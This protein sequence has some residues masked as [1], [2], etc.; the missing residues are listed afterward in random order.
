M[1]QLR[2]CYE[3]LRMS[4]EKLTSVGALNHPSRKLPGEEIAITFS[5]Q[6]FPLMILR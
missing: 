6:F 4:L 2:F 5:C 1:S 3:S